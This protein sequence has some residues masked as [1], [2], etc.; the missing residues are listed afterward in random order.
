MADPQPVT[1]WLDHDPTQPA[2]T[3]WLDHDPIPTGGSQAN[4]AM[5]SG[6]L[7]T[8]RRFEAGLASPILNLPHALLHPIQTAQAAIPGDEADDNYQRVKNDPHSNFAQKAAAFLEAA[9]PVAGPAAKDIQDKYSSGDH[10]GALGAAASLA[11]SV[12]AP[13]ALAG[14]AGSIATGLDRAGSAMSPSVSGLLNQ[15]IGLQMSDLPK[16]ARSNPARAADIGNTVFNETGI[17]NT[18]A[19]QKAAIDGAMK[20]RTAATED[21]LNQAGGSPIDGS[22]LLYHHALQTMQDLHSAGATESQLGAIDPNFEG[23]HDEFG[24]VMT[25]REALDMRRTIGSKVKDWNPGTQ[26][27]TQQFLQNVYHGLN[28]KIEGALPDG[29]KQLYRENN[30]IVSNLRTASDAAGEKLTKGELVPGGLN[31]G[32][33]LGTFRH[34]LVAG[35]ARL[36]GDAAPLGLVNK[37]STVP[38]SMLHATARGIRAVDPYTG[39]PIAASPFIPQDK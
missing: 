30:R 34:G 6:A 36:A 7:D 16:F 11:G 29:T 25:P 37:V 15:H 1:Q 3:Q 22:H 21:M 9:I 38:S 5:L 27:P 18:V 12:L 19:E 10:A 35:T 4:P 14:K 26:N 32:S 28:D 17:K 24:K 39:I 31:I 2:Q 8:A 23:L 13:E 20:G 33:A